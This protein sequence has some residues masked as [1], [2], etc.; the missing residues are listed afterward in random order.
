MKK[1]Q[2]SNKRDVLIILSVILLVLA[3]IMALISTSKIT[4]K[5]EK[6]LEYKEN[7]HIGYDIKEDNIS[8]DFD[9]NFLTDKKISF[10]YN[11]DI[12]ATIV[13]TNK[14]TGK[15]L[16]YNQIVLMPSKKI[17]EVDTATYSIK[18]SLNI[19]YEE[20]EKIV[21]EKI[22]KQDLNKIDSYV[23][24]SLN[25]NTFSND[26]SE[27][28]QVKSSSLIKIPL[29]K[30]D[31]FISKKELKETNY[32]VGVKDELIKNKKL[33]AIAII[34]TS[35]SL[36]ILIGAF[37]L[38]LINPN[39]ENSY[40]REYKKVVKMVENYDEL[41]ER[42]YKIPSLKE[43]KIIE[44]SNIA[45]FITLRDKYDLTITMVDEGDIVIFLMFH[46]NK[47]W[48]YIIEKK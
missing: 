22:N 26:F 31:P 46:N 39:I 47:A 48:K 24:I 3:V 27:K 5:T 15:N 37:I 33:F 19:N 25:T 10:D 12:T 18:E 4:A 41:I 11:Y 45:D 9:Y 2:K 30:D 43:K 20:Y 35:L 42:V 1:I 16:L 14:E 21:K 8:I 13:A 44:V 23:E 29:L 32:L 28:L 6:L 17:G 7:S 40:N 36:I 38:Y 34:M